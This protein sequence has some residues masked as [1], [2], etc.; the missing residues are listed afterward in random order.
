MM[1]QWFTSLNKVEKRTF[2][3]CFSGWGLDAM[4]T[5][6]YALSIPTLIAL[7]GM[8]KGEA[9]I[10]GTTVLIMAALGGG[11]DCRHLVG[12]LR[13]GEDPAGD[14]RLVF[15]VHLPFR[16]HRLILATA[17]D[18]QPARAGIRR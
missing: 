4:D 10:L 18:P 2:W 1:F 17:A 13:A 15:T 8:T 11:L 7:W 14:H 3:A 16:L 9:G 5:Q 12:S 6:M